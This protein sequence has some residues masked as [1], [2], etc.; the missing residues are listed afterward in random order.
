MTRPTIKDLRKQVTEYCRHHNLRAG[1]LSEAWN[2]RD[3]F[4]RN[5]EFPNS[6][7]KGCYVLTDRDDDLGEVIYVGKASIGSGTMG[8]ELVGFFKPMHSD[9][10]GGVKDQ[11]FRGT[12][13]IRTLPVENGA[14]GLRNI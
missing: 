12:K 11:R 5:E 9:D 1:P 7:E 14:L 4:G 8:A 10:P 6:R 2:V 13:Y 3:G